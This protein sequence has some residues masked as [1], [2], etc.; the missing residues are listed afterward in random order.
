MTIFPNNIIIFITKYKSETKNLP[1]CDI[2]HEVPKNFLG[3][4]PI[5]PFTGGMIFESKASYNTIAF[6]SNLANIFLAYIASVN[7]DWFAL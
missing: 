5:P 4:E 1:I 7:E 6:Q 3:L 2:S